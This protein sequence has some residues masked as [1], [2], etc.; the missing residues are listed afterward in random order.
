[1]RHQIKPLVRGRAE[2]FLHALNQIDRGPRR[3]PNSDDEVLRI[4]VPHL[5]IQELVLIQDLGAAVEIGALSCFP[6]GGLVAAA[7]DSA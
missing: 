6:P 2:R 3:Y 7:R 5:M 4:P 1:V